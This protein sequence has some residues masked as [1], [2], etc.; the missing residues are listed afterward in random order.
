MPRKTQGLPT[1]AHNNQNRRPL[2]TT[3][4]P[5]L[6]QPFPPS[7][8]PPFS[9]SCTS[10]L[11]TFVISHRSI[12]PPPLPPSFFIRQSLLPILPPYIRLPAYASLNQIFSQSFIPRITLLILSPLRFLSV[13]HLYLSPSICYLYTHLLSIYLCFHVVDYRHYIYHCICSFFKYMHKQSN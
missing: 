6:L 1:H 9:P 8:S 7:E 12:L 13:P 2:P 5:S 11:P 3:L 10:F 4:L